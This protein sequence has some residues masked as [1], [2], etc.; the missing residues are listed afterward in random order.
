MITFEK[1]AEYCSANDITISV[2]KYKYGYSLDL[3]RYGDRRGEIKD[4]HLLRS[5]YGHGVTLDE[6]ANDLVRKL[7]GERIV[8]GAYSDF[9]T[10]FDFNF[11]EGM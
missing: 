8:F 9:R 6:A 4:G 7:N 5:F 10:E 3:M 2:M 1:L 11:H